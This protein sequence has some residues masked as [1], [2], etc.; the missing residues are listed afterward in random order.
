MNCGRLV[1][2]QPTGAIRDGRGGENCTLSR[3]DRHQYYFSSL[4]IAHSQEG[5]IE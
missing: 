1:Y 4:L 2:F 5:V 3:S